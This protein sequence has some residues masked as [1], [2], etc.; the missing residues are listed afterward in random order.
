MSDIWNVIAELGLELHP[1]RVTA[2]AN[3]IKSINSGDDF[4]KIRRGLSPNINVKLIDLLEKNWKQNKQVSSIEIASALMSASL[5]AELAAS[6]GSVEMVWTGPSSNLVPIRH[7][8]QV[9]KE[10]I[11]SAKT[12][13]FVVSF[14]A[15]DVP[16]IHSAL[17]RAIER[18][19]SVDI[20]VESSQNPHSRIQVDSVPRMRSSVPKANI[21]IWD[22]SQNPSDTIGVVHAKCAV[23]DDC[24]AFITSANLTTAAMERNVELGVLIKGG[25][26]PTRLDQHLRSLVVSKIFKKVN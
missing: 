12:K 16:T 25:D 21:Y 22:Q 15:Y 14:V 10:V 11:E 20:L 6:R 1:A 23:A 4:P 26:L 13:L 24:I 2:L 8:E 19:V 7:T 5:T 18:N 3:L 17:N 9:L